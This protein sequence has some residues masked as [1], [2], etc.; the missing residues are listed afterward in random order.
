MNRAQRKSEDRDA[1]PDSE[2]LIRMAYSLAMGPEGYEALFDA[3]QAHQA[4]RIE[5]AFSDSPSRPA[6]DLDGVEAHFENALAMLQSQGRR[7]LSASSAIRTLD[8][9]IKPAL[10]LSA[11]GGVL[12]ANPAARDFFGLPEPWRLEAEQ[13]E[14]GHHGELLGHLA[15]LESQPENTII[16]IFGLHS[17]HDGGLVKMSLS[18]TTGWRGQPVGLLSALHISWYPDIGQRFR[19]MMGLTQVELQITRAIVTGLPLSSVSEQRGSKLSTVRNQTKSLLKKL[20]VR[21]QTELACLYSG[22]SRYSLESP[23]AAGTGA[24]AP[25]A[26]PPAVLAVRPGHVIDYRMAG[27]PR[28]R[29]VLYL[30]AMLGGRAVTQ[31]MQAALLRHKVRLIMPWRPGFSGSYNA[32]PGADPF[33]DTA[34][35]V[36][37][38]LDA[39]SIDRLPVVGQMTSTMHAFAAAH[40]L[41]DR[42]S[43]LMALAPG[44]PTVRGAHLRH[45]GRAQKLRSLL[46][47]EAPRVGRLIAHAF[48]SR[49][50]AGYDVE[51]IR[52]YLK[53]SRADLD[54]SRRDETIHAFRDAYEDTHAQG[55]EGFIEELALFGSDWHALTDGLDIPVRYVVGEQETAFPPAAVE[56]FAATFLRA[57]VDCVPEAGHLV[58]YEAPDR[59]VAALAKMAG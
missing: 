51:F 7:K 29:P 25:R 18:R 27:A 56:A 26:T 3:L 23:A 5:T 48:L 1:A 28:G 55:Y 33:R 58:A 17:V 47:R 44:L 36:Q 34:A 13:F 45:V 38:L 40:H 42:I 14:P 4:G 43:G 32:A 8:A 35:E 41:P 9:S 20:G 37:A 21:S 15:T 24:S 22:F 10:T 19:D 52:H 49:V 50:D 57:E 2:T 39:L 31:E 59:W 46:T 30:P 54:F 12:H 16:A 6:S 11:S 53:D